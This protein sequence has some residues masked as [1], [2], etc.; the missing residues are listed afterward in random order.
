MFEIP[1]SGGQFPTS[2]STNVFFKAPSSASIV[3]L[4]RDIS[5]KYELVNINK[6]YTYRGSKNRGMSNNVCDIKEK[7]KH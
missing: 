5:S 6:G 2:T 3:R 1:E 4:V 7:I